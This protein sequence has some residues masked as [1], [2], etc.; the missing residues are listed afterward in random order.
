MKLSKYIINYTSNKGT[1]WFNTTNGM[2]IKITQSNLE[3][4]PDALHWLKDNHFTLSSEEEDKLVSDIYHKQLKEFDRTLYLTVEITTSCN[5]H[6]NFC[7][8]ASWVNRK[9]IKAETIDNLVK[10]L[11]FSNTASYSKLH[12]NII[13]GE[14]MLFTDI[15]EYLLCSIRRFTSARGLDYEVKLNSNGYNLTPD[16]I[17]NTL[18]SGTF[19][20]P[21]L[22]PID[23]S[24]NLVGLKSGHI[25]LREILLSKIYSWKDAFNEDPSKTIIFRYNVNDK[26]LTYFNHYVE[27]VISFGFKKFLID[28]VNTADCD[29]NHYRNQLSKEKFDEWYYKDAVPFL[30]SKKLSIPIK[31]RC[32]LSRCKA[33]RKG[34]F[35]IFADGRIGL[36]NG[37]EYSETM[38]MIEEITSLCDID[39]LFHNVKSFHYLLDDSECRNCNR[40]FL[41]GGPSPCKGKV[42]R[43]NTENVKKYIDSFGK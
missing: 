36:C 24:T 40:I 33:R 28:V 22:S 23:Y 2:L 6:C 43:G 29:S 12:L 16:F 3:N 41:C 26:N 9:V 35:K 10:I 37:I 18:P 4:N 21:F 42:C 5:F 31:P 39:A 30:I 17:R 8:Q 34:S 27:E 32:E 13:G 20:F 38:P 1:Y 14:P 7:Y 25:N 15:V 19:M 11:N